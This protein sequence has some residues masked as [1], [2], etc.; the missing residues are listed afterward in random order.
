MCKLCIAPS[1]K[2]SGFDRVEI[3]RRIQRP[4]PQTKLHCIV[5]LKIYSIYTRYYSTGYAV[6]EVHTLEKQTS[7]I[8]LGIHCPT[9]R[10]YETIISPNDYFISYT[11]YFV[12]RSHLIFRNCTSVKSYQSQCRLC[13][14]G[15]NYLQMLQILRL[16]CI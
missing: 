13:G 2:S 16:N 6:L 5:R 10:N 1:S 8:R 12:I 9:C 3:C 14:W 15:K 7:R 4:T 11:L